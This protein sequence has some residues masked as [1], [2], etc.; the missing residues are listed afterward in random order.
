[1]DFKRNNLDKANSPYLKQHKDN[2]VHWQEWKKEVIEY[3]KA[4][5]KMLFVSVGY[6][7]CHWC[8]V[9][10]Q[11]AFSDKG[12]ANYLNEHFVSIKVDKEQRPDINNYLMAFLTSMTGQGGWPLNVFL[13]SDIKP[14]FGL[15][16]AGL[17]AKY[18]MPGFMEILKAV[19]ERGGGS[20]FHPEL[21]APKTI[22]SDKLIQTIYD[23]FD[24]YYHGFGQ[25]KFPP[26]CTLL[27]ML[28]Y[29]QET[30][31][32]KLREMIEKTLD[33]MMKSGLHD[34]LQGGFFRYCVDREW[35]TPHFEK[36]LYDQAML[37]WVYSLAFRLIEKDEYKLVA[38]KIVKCLH[39]T[40]ESNGLFYS[41]IDA[42]TNHHEG[43]TYLWSKEELK[44]DAIATAYSMENNFE[45]KIHLIKN[46][47]TFSDELDRAESALLEIRKK[48]DQPHTD[49]KIITS[50]NCLAGIGLIH[51]YRYLGKKI[52][53]D[54]AENLFDALI[55]SHYSARLIHSS[56]D[57]VKEKEEFLEDYASLLLFVT[58]L[59][60]E[61]NNYENYLKELSTAI[62]KFKKKEWIESH[63]DDFIEVAA[64]AFDHPVPSSVS[65]A[66]LAICRSNVLLKKEYIGDEEFKM[67][68]HFDFFNISVLF[69]KGLFHIIET[70]TLIDWRK[71]SINTMQGR[72]KEFM[73][74]Y[75]GVCS[76]DT[77]F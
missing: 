42:D 30:K 34:H 71:I 19:K 51:A 43:E 18:G 28:H 77:S 32:D 62:M 58:Y 40:F 1:M 67:P 46:K 17:H 72:G 24:H 11:E 60:E 8:H 37:L 7:T 57:G 44:N 56:I 61:T 73:R 29:Y 41:G 38:E 16:Y 54:M 39:E 21:S 75:K 10:A 14:I 15:T 35:R 4:Q 47:N 12:I 20:E 66:E 33:T 25:P 50:W 9:M 36:M 59:H 2:P 26:H 69:K 68:L 64:E 74:C 31:D 63:N 22:E 13:S 49:K 52:Y 27:F 55:K 53:L 45:G 3:A 65:M 70:P 23:N 76:T 6:S 48:R 5:G